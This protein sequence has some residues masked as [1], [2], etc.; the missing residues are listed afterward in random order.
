MFSLIANPSAHRFSQTV[1][2]EVKHWFELHNL[3]LSIHL[4]EG[5]QHATELAKKSV[6]AGVKTVIAMGGDGTVREVAKGLIGSESSLALLPFGTVNVLAKDI[7]LPESLDELLE[8][9]VL[10]T[11]KKIKTGLI[12]LRNQNQEEITEPFL[13]MAGF[14]MDAWVCREMNPSAKKWSGQGAYFFAGIKAMRQTFPAFDIHTDNEVRVGHSLV[15]ANSRYYAGEYTLCAEAG[16]LKPKFDTCLI[17]S[18]SLVHLGE[19][20]MKLAQN[21]HKNLGFLK[22]FP[23]TEILIHKPGIPVQLDGDYIGMTPAKV[24]SRPDSLSI[25]YPN[26]LGDA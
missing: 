18:D 4:T 13:L 7:G 20:M 1:I 23:A 19:L 9:C 10:G 24:E 8:V 3:N 11:R 25:C 2:D 15:V 21:Q 22:F 16:L 26:P 5:P 14:G 12:H 6:R 17:Q